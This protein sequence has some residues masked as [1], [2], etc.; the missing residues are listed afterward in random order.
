MRST[1]RVFIVLALI[2]G[3]LLV[4]CTTPEAAVEE[5]VAN[6][7]DVAEAEAEVDA[8]EPE[9]EPTE[10]P[11]PTAV[12]EPV[13]EMAEEP[14]AVAELSEEE[15]AAA[16]ASFLADMQAYNTIN[17]EDTNAALAEDPPPFLLDVREISEVEEKGHI[18][19]A[20]LIPL[21]ELAQQTEV[22]PSQDTPIIAYCGSGWRATVAMAALEAM[23]YEDVKVLKGSS[24]NGWI[25]AGYP[26]VEGLPPEALVL[27]IADINPALLARM[28]EMLSAIP[29][30]W[31]V[32]TAEQLNTELIDNPELILID[33]RTEGEV[34]EK[35][36]T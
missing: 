1:K 12:P 6:E 17:L 15:L 5:P 35:G 19:G 14:E 18:E 20:V 30:G 27:D 36:R 33:V 31:G 25:E 24:Y 26:T 16:F 23:G 2:L 9:P 3:L 28:D 13:E 8:E 21:R 7:A 10:E 4:A 32:I 34:A 22:L 29:E 11:E